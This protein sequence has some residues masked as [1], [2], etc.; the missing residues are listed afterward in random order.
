[1]LLNCLIL[2]KGSSG[3]NVINTVLV[4]KKHVYNVLSNIYFFLDTGTRPDASINFD[5][6]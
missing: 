6:L 2:T 3:V 5:P 4:N 1:M